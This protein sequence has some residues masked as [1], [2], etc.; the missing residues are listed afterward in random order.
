MNQL[1]ER[2]KQ[3]FME[4]QDKLIEQTSKKK[5]VRACAACDAGP[6]RGLLTL[7]RQYAG[8][9]SVAVPR[10]RAEDGLT[11]CRGAQHFT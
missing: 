7:T 5:Q 1:D 11:D 6:L 8:R 3:A 9:C 4:L 2:D 10:Q